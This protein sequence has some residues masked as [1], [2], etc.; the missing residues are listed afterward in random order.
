MELEEAVFRGQERNPDSRKQPGFAGS[1][2]RERCDP[3]LDPADARLSQR[4]SAGAQG[5][6]GGISPG[7][8]LTGSWVAELEGHGA[9]CPRGDAS[10]VPREQRCRGLAQ[11]LG[12]QPSPGDCSSSS[13]IRTEDF[14]ARFREG[15]VE[16]LLFSEEEDE[17]PAGDV[18]AEGGD[19][20]RDESA[21]RRRDVQRLLAVE[22]GRRPLQGRSP[23]L[24]RRES[25]ES[26]GGRISRLS[27]RGALGMAWGGPR[28]DPSTQ[29]ALG[30]EDSPH[31]GSRSRKDPLSIAL[32]S[33]D[34]AA[35]RPWR[36]SGISAGRS[37]AGARRGSPDGG[38]PGPSGAGSRGHPA[39]KPL[40]LRWQKP[41]ALQGRCG[42]VVTL[43]VDDVEKEGAG[44]RQRR[45]PCPAH[46]TDRAAGSPGRRGTGADVSSRPGAVAA[47]SRWQ[48]GKQKAVLPC[49]PAAG[50][51]ASLRWSLQR[52]PGVTQE[53]GSVAK[54]TRSKGDRARAG[55]AP[56]AHTQD[57]CH[58][59]PTDLEMTWRQGQRGCAAC[60][61]A[62][63]EER[64]N[65]SPLQE[66]KL[67]LQ[68]RLR[69]LEHG[70]R[71]LLRQ[72]QQALD[73]L[74]VLFQKEKV[75]ALRQLQEALEKE[76]AGRS[77]WLWARLQRLE[78][79][80]SHPRRPVVPGQAGCS[81]AMGTTSACQCRHNPLPDNALGQGPSPAAVSHALRIL[82]GLREQIQ[83]HLEELRKE[84]GAQG[85]AVWRKKEREQR[86]QR[87][88]LCMEKATALGALREQLIQ[89]RR[90]HP[91]LHPTSS[92]SMSTVP[93]LRQR[94]C[95]SLGILHH[96]Q[97]CVQELQ[98]EKTHHTGSLG[99]LTAL[100]GE[101]GPTAREEIWGQRG[102]RESPYATASPKQEKQSST[103]EHAWWE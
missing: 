26:L 8:F 12:S 41:P 64:R 27:Q 36:A 60:R 18:P 100:G 46:R 39:S 99:K 54:G 80:L 88:Q 89:R 83:H 22:P 93:G 103:M 57:S 91:H 85:P 40:G 1:W 59:H 50:H 68:K 33:E 42:A 82:R 2:A 71:S 30:R 90:E 15:M 84:D 47:E 19:L 29:P 73:Q 56:P 78:H 101:L 94:G 7:T 81:P 3:G 74:H 32:R 38:L 35:G 9:G 95:G 97:R 52:S 49:K 48:R 31:Q 62:L 6:G 72:R 67:E 66:E 79:L 23:P 65:T 17:E 25:L 98:L 24:M 58:W 63:G 92:L 86:Q 4:H 55:L 69:D 14:A 13:S 77:A 20:G 28:P 61:E 43:A 5:A 21:G 11:P 96:L 44:R 70:T 102:T 75:D 76:R 34:P 87:E 53:L 37:R 16:P 10:P 45:A 51:P